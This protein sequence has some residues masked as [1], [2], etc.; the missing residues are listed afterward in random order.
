MTL[1]DYGQASFVG[2]GLEDHSAQFGG[3]TSSNWIQHEVYTAP[4]AN[5]VINNYSDT[6]T[7]QMYV[8][9]ASQPTLGAESSRTATDR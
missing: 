6:L 8:A 7:P 4:M 9:C 5:S 2:I 3:P 1:A